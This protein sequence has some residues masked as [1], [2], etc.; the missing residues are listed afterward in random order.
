MWH[1]SRCRFR[2]HVARRTPDVVTLNPFESLV[3]FIGLL[4]GITLLLGIAAPTSLVLLLP[5]AAY[6]VYAVALCLGGGTVAYGLRGGMR[7]LALAA[8]LQ[9]LGGAF[10][11]YGI[12]TIALAGWATAALA[13]AAYGALGLL[14]LI[15][16]QHF[17]RLID[18]QRGARRL[19]I[20]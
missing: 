15:R 12:A 10:G 6:Y 9:L 13:L 14:C 11:I 16:A 4:I 1:Q 20:R 19:E 7:P 18:I 3:A 17:R 8:G 5:K 2:A